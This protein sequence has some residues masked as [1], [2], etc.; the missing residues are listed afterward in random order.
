MLYDYKCSKC[1]TVFE[2]NCRMSE[3]DNKWECPECGSTETEK[4]ITFPGA[5]IPPDR[6]GRMR[7]PDGFNDVL[8]HMSKHAISGHLL[9]D[10]V[11]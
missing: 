8:K 2:K 3:R 11:R 9:R 4:Q 5:L 7:H 1:E 6:L 10:K